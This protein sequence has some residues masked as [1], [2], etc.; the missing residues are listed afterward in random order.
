MDREAIQQRFGIVGQSAAIRNVI[1]RARMVARTDITVLLQGE[2]GVGKELIAHAIHGMSPRR[3]GPFVIVNCGAI[4]EGLIE[5]ELF[6][7][8][9]GAY[10]GAVERRKGYFEEAD[11]GTIFL[12]EIGEMPLA[13]QVRL[14][15]VLETGEFTRVGS[16]RPIKTDVRIIAATNKDLAK[17]VR[18]GQFREDLYYRISTV[19]IEIPPLRERREDI[20]PLFEYFLHRAA[21]RY[22]TPLRRLDESARQLLLRYHWPG[23]VRELR[24]VAEQVAVLLT[25]TTITAEDL[26]PLLRGVSAGRSLM[27]VSRPSEHGGD[28]RE[29]ELIYRL[30]LELRL[31]MHE[32]KALLHRLVSGQVRRPE[33]LPAPSE[34]PAFRPSPSWTEAEDADFVEDVPFEEELDFEP[35]ETHDHWESEQETLRE[36]ATDQ[37]EQKT[38]EQSPASGLLNGERLP[39]LAEA[40]RMLIVEA[41]KRYGGNRR[42]AA[43]ALGISERT[44]YRKLKEIDE[45]L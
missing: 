16:S 8:E 14:L 35:V 34:E 45:A 22:G 38:A 13:A 4:P 41:L 28:P 30:L 32:I 33:Q 25:K 2:S 7:A 39:T 9:K 12:D 19:I 27:P 26:R 17:A 3:H 23:N 40:E 18:A 29:R 42:Q 20:I 5:S 44:L 37:H 6:G 36:A 1:D 11:G 15:R 24:N 21:Q 43:R 10:T 31:D